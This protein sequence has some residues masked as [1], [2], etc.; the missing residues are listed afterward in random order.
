MLE[1][2]NTPFKY[3]IPINFGKLRTRNILNLSLHVYY[4]N[5]L[6]CKS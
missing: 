6:I 1:K 4:I 3:V 2:R 5:N